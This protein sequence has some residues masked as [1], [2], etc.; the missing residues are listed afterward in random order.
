M[1]D[2]APEQ[3]SKATGTNTTAAQVVA[4]LRRHPDF[5]AR[6]PELLDLQLSPGRHGGDGIIDLQQFMVERLRGEIN[7]LR[8]DQDEI[9]ANTR[10]NISTQERIHKAV[11]ELL[12][13]ESFEQF[14]D[15]IT[16]DLGLLLEV[17]VVSLCVE[18]SD[19]TAKRPK[20]EGIQF[21]GRGAIDRLLGGKDKDVVLRDEAVGDPEIF[22]PAA[23]LVRSDAL[24]RLNISSHAPA[25]LIA[26]GARHP[27][28]F[29]A[30]QGTELM[31]F[32][33]RVME[34][35]IRTWLDLPKP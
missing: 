30:G 18:L 14:I 7:K 33:G 16:G 17:D 24:L 9:L 27:G 5:L 35:G 11:V 10:D 21:L 6:H 2:R 3:G 29:H 12:E 28:Y 4:Y 34:F 32:L 13:A 23:D 19:H 1:A 8:G 26:F 31:S 15:I 20:H 25:G 22:G